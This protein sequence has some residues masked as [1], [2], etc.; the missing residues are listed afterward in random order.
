MSCHH[1]FPFHW[2]IDKVEPFVVSALHDLSSLI[3]SLEGERKKWSRLDNKNHQSARQDGEREKKGMND[4]H[5]NY[6]I[7]LYFSFC[8][9]DA[10][11]PHAF[12]KLA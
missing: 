6:A 2:K 11:M 12:Y 4:V 7:T 3:H 9:E 1:F 10:S 8:A 5:R